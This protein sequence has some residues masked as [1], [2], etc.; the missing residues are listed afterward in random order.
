MGAS[1]AAEEETIYTDLF[2]G[3]RSWNGRERNRLLL[4][5]G[6][7]PLIDVSAATGADDRRDGRGMAVS[8]FDHDGD[9][10]FAV[11]NYEAPASLWI[12]RWGQARGW[13]AVRLEGRKGNRDAI[14]A[15]LVAHVGEARMLRVVGAGHGYAG[16]NSLEQLFGL[17]DAAR[18][19][20]LEVRWP[21]GSRERFGPLAAGTRVRLVQGEGAAPEGGVEES[22][23]GVPLVPPPEDFEL[24]RWLWLAM[25]IPPLFLIGMATLT[26][27]LGSGGAEPQAGPS[28]Q[29]P[30]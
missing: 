6:R 9:V 22:Q 19:D 26:R 1:S 17:G 8:D 29:P 12:N 3:P 13:V 10:D 11:A 15:T 16:Q 28:E 4:N 20:A 25:I 5:T 24:P 23:A 7:W 18:I 30:A 14:G 2:L 27:K 21:D